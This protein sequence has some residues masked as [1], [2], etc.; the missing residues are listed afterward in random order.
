MYKCYD[1]T[2]EAIAV[3]NMDMNT[4]YNQAIE[5]G[6]EA[7]N[8]R[9]HDLISGSVGGFTLWKLLIPIVRR[10]QD[11][12]KLHS[13]CFLMNVSILCFFVLCC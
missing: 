4:R 13:P 7:E 10:G 9:C 1:T 5:L 2:F 8:A 12:C 11:L 6:Q 3:W